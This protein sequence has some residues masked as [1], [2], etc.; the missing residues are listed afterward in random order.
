MAHT[1]TMQNDNNNSTILGSFPHHLAQHASLSWARHDPVSR[2]RHRTDYDIITTLGHGAFGTTYK[3]RN[4]I[5]SRIYAMKTVKLGGSGIIGNGSTGSTEKECDRVLREVEVLSGV[6][7]DNVV[8]YYGAWLEK[9]DMPSASSILRDSSEQHNSLDESYEFSETTASSGTELARQVGLEQDPMCHLCKSSYKDWEVSFEQWGLIDAVLQPLNLC[10]MCYMDSVPQQVDASMIVIREKQK[11]PVY[12]F[13]LMEFCEST[14]KEAVK[15]CSGDEEVLWSLFAQCVQG[16]AHLHSRQIIHRDVKPGNIFVHDGVVKIGDLGLATY[17]SSDIRSVIENTSND[18]I[19]QSQNCI[20]LVGSKSSQVG[21]FLY[22]APEVATGKYDEKCD[23]YSLG[24][25]LVEMFSNFDTAM[26][27]ADVLMRLRSEGCVPAEWE[28]ARP[29]QSRLAKR[30]VALEPAD[31]PSCGEILT[32]LL[33]E[34]LWTKVDSTT[35]ATTF[36]DL[37]ARIVELEAKLNCNDQKMEEL[38][39][40]LYE[41]GISHGHMN[42]C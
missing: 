4:K 15:Q 39:R 38:Q 14:L 3:V 31:R 37:K 5:D 26:E 23:V 7:G 18:G 20:G 19:V 9:G 1:H 11:L 42:G 33:Q 24:I 41:K 22:T 8:R 29:I 6:S 28:E 10:T 34:G 35:M 27:R 32:E 36:V 21:T 25:V 16:L 30:M 17:A 2:T 12:L 40:L 13:I